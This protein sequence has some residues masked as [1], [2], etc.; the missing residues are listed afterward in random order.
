M[1]LTVMPEEPTDGELEAEL[2]AFRKLLDLGRGT[3]FLAREDVRARS[4]IMVKTENGWERGMTCHGG[5]YR[6]RARA[7]VDRINLGEG[8]QGSK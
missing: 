4:I 6:E 5:D 3:A 2:A 8:R 7:F 1:N